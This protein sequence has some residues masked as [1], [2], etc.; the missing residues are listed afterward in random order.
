M[1]RASE[2]DTTAS[3]RR[4]FL[5][6]AAG[7]GGAGVS[8]CTDI[9]Q[10]V[11]NGGEE[12]VSLTI[13]AMLAD[14]ED[15]SSS[16]IGRE[17]MNHMEAIGISAE[18]E[19]VTRSELLRSVLFEHDFDCYVGQLPPVERA[20]ELYTLFHSQF[21]SE[22]GWQNPT[23]Y[24]NVAADQYLDDLLREGG[25]ASLEQFLD[26]FTTEAPIIPICRAEE[27]RCARVDRLTGWDRNELD[28][29]R[30]YLGL[31]GDADEF[32][33][34]IT[35]AEP[36]NNLNP[37]AAV[38]QGPWPFQY[39][40]Y[41]SLILP[42][43]SNYQEWMAT[44]VSLDGM[45]IDVS[46]RSDLQ[47]HDGESVTA[48]DVVFTY[49]LISDITLGQAGSP[50]AAPVYRWISNLVVDGSGSGQSLELELQQIPD[51]WW[52]VLSV[53]IVP[54]HIWED[55]LDDIST[56]GILDPTVPWGD[57]LG[58]DIPEIGSGPFK[59]NDRSEDESLT[60]NRFEDHFSFADPELPN[61]S[62]SELNVSVDPNQSVL[63]D[64]I[65]DGTIDMVG[66]P[67]ETHHLSN[68]ENVSSDVELLPSDRRR[69][70]HIG[71]NTRERPFSNWRFREAVIGL[72]DYEWIINEVFHGRADPVA[73][74]LADTQ[75]PEDSPYRW[76]GSHP[77]VEFYGSPGTNELNAEIAEKAFIDAGYRYDENGN[78]VIFE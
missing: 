39:M 77:L 50:L 23:G 52:R 55:E 9:L 7:L 61:P 35:S 18:V 63:I 64:L 10:R 72:L 45:T 74:P 20:D 48:E 69:V 30:G 17:L 11:T 67:F 12:Q 22:P 66:E 34:S 54:K 44:A 51:E 41:D 62:I 33:M 75:L 29:L 15:R 14:D 26:L 21:A 53:P 47:F 24:A 13:L 19:L 70:Y 73:T 71:F 27:Y 49:D 60:L 25:N 36:T 57:A 16:R 5:A 6:T 42:E 32:Q 4:R 40:I 8:G 2:S 58:E 46:L 76:Q 65:D 43:G 3:S 1:E 78:L 38:Y 37:F 31:A 28:R 56:D 59:L 68:L